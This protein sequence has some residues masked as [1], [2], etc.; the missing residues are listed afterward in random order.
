MAEESVEAQLR[1]ACEECHAR[2]IRCELSAATNGGRC[3]ACALNQRQCLFSLRSRTGR[4]RKQPLSISSKPHKASPSTRHH[5]PAAETGPSDPQQASLA[6]LGPGQHMGKNYQ[7][8]TTGG[9]LHD[10][11]GRMWGPDDAGWNN[12]STWQAQEPGPGLASP[13]VSFDTFLAPDLRGWDT[14]GQLI[15]HGTG[16]DSLS[17]RSIDPIV[18]NETDGDGEQG[19]LDA[20]KLYSGLHNTCKS[21]TLDLLTEADCYK[22]RVICRLFDELS[23]AAHALQDNTLHASPTVRS[24]MSEAKIIAVALGE[25]IQVC[26]DIIQHNFQIHQCTATTNLSEQ[27]QRR[28]ARPDSR[29]NQ[30][31]RVCICLADVDEKQLGVRQNGLELLICLEFSLIRFHHVM[32][33]AESLDAGHP[34]VTCDG[35]ISSVP[36]VDTARSQVSA[37][38]KH[39][40]NLQD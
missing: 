15:M 12:G 9:P 28:P 33:K 4:P 36:K 10:S 1:L 35:G 2:K 34:E 39:F 6:Q 13:P 30:V 40:R 31:T 20:L 16:I 14:L 38:L 32:S 5:R 37:L 21:T 11:Q 3:K 17:D 18:L 7:Q 8:H 27:Q 25:A 19:F 22:V 29:N 23:Q 26:I 24:D